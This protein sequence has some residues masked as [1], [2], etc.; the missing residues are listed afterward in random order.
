M[1][2]MIN[3]LHRRKKIDVEIQI[4]YNNRPFVLPAEGGKSVYL[5]VLSEQDMEKLQAQPVTV[6]QD[7]GPSVEQ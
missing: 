1:D 5:C 7:E 3:Y 4:V 6:S 2:I